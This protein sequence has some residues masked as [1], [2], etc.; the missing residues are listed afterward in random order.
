MSHNYRP[1]VPFTTNIVTRDYNIDGSDDPHTVVTIQAHDPQE[2][3]PVHLTNIKFN[4][5]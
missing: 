3:Y 2:P 5:N 4:H 1:A